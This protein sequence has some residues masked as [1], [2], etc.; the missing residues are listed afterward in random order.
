VGGSVTTPREGWRLAGGAG[1]ASPV[2][3]LVRHPLA[4]LGATWNETSGVPRPPANRQAAM[5]KGGGEG[6]WGCRAK[7]GSW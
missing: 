5:G 2:D 1:R 7:D 4:A 3:D 6:V